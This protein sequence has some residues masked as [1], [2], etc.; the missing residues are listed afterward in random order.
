MTHKELA[1]RLIFVGIVAAGSNILGDVA[2]GRSLEHC[3]DLILN[4]W[5]TLCMTYCALDRFC[6][7]PGDAK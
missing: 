6:L 3:I 7:R 2:F 4:D 5:L 1:Q